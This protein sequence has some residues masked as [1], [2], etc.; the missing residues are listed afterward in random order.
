MARILGITDHPPN[1]AGGHLDDFSSEHPAGTNFVMGDGSVRLVT[2]TINLNV[3]RA[4]AT[5]SGGE[6]LGDF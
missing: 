1:A 5:R 2:E 4:L 6:V 3:Y